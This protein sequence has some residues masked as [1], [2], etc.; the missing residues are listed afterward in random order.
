M[1]NTQI[2]EALNYLL[3]QGNWGAFYGDANNVEEFEANFSWTGSGV[4]P[5]WDQ[6]STAIVPPKPEP[7]VAEKLASV[8]LSISD[9]KK[10]LGL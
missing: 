4:K 9:L 10:A 2:A 8:G 6:V 7:T 1:T 5:T 3:P